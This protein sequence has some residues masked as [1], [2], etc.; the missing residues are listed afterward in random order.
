MAC[1]LP[2][3]AHAKAIPAKLLPAIMAQ[4]ASSFFLFATNW[5]RLPPINSIAFSAIASENGEA[6][7]ER[8]ASI[9]WISA[10]T[11]QAAAMEAGAVMISSGSR[12]AYFGR[13][14]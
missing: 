14:S 9:A 13:I 7:V 2:S 5:R 6:F 11:P 12:T 1:T 3:L 8:Y 10:S 4:A